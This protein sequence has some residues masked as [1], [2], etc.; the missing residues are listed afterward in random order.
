MNKCPNCI[1]QQCS[2]FRVGRF[3]SE[4]TR[5]KFHQIKDQR[6]KEFEGHAN[7]TNPVLHDALG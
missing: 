2:E 1:F 4:V 3:I 7:L 6:E 5:C